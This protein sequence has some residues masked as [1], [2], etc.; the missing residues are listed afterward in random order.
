MA[1]GKSASSYRSAISGR[2][3]TARHGAASPRTTV[4]EAHGGGPTGSH[5]SAVTGR[6]VSE[7]YAKTHQKTTV[8]E[9]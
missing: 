8:K 7:H 2:Y 6:F 5:R 9:S 3:V 1:K 4:K